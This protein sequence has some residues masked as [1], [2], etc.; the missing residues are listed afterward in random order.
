[1][2]SIKCSYQT[3]CAVYE[4][5]FLEMP[6]KMK[7]SALFQAAKNTRIQGRNGFII[8]YISEWQNFSMASGNKLPYHRFCFILEKKGEINMEICMDAQ[9]NQQMKVDIKVYEH[10]HWPLFSIVPYVC[11]RFRGKL[12]IIHIHAHW[13]LYSIRNAVYWTAATFNEQ[14]F[15]G[16]VK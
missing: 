9:V 11:R 4:G 2:G 7:G 13:I 14:Q 12:Q 3:A 8:V 5:K 6:D 16:G 10:E 1:M 15:H